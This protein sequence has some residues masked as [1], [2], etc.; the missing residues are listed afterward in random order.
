VSHWHGDWTRGVRVEKTADL[1]AQSPD[2]FE[3]VV[4]L[5]AAKAIGL[6]VR[7]SII[8]LADEVI[9]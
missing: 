8:L 7:D 9:E 4:N 2:K 6:T 1:P 3:F 5:Q